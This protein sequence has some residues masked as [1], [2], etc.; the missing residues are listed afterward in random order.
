MIMLQVLDLHT[1]YVLVILKIFSREEVGGFQEIFD[2]R[3]D[4]ITLCPGKCPN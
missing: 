4:N 1:D 3:V 2:L